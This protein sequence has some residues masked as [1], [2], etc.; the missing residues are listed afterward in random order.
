LLNSAIFAALIVH[1]GS[2][3]AGKKTIKLDVYGILKPG[4]L[5]SVSIQMVPLENLREVFTCAGACTCE[6]I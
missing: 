4:L 2:P 3:W 1:K 5:S 6:C